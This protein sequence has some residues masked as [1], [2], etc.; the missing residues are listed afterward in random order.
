LLFDWA[1]L[2]VQNIAMKKE[3]NQELRVKGLL[4]S[5][6]LLALLNRLPNLLHAIGKSRKVDGSGKLYLSMV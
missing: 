3:F 4:G 1:G 6:K 5:L 2:I